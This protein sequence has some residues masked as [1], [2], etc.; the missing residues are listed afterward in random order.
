MTSKMAQNM[1]QSKMSN[2]KEF[3][4]VSMETT[5][6]FGIIHKVF[7]YSLLTLKEETGL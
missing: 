4:W 1:P 6:T 3:Y 2:N 5:L 7:R